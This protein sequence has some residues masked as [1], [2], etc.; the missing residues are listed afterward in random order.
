MIKIY[1]TKGRCIYTAQT[2]K[3][4]KEAV[5]QAAKRKIPLY[6]ANLCRANLRGA[7]LRGARLNHADLRMADLRD[8]DLHDADLTGADWHYA[9]M[10][11]LQYNWFAVPETF[12][13]PP[14]THAS[15]IADAK[16][17]K[18]RQQA[19]KDRERARLHRI[20]E[21]RKAEKKRL[22]AQV[23]AL[24]DQAKKRRFQARAASAA[25]RQQMAQH[26]EQHP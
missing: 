4:I 2:A 14:R 15:K 12:E 6:G 23:C 17:E 8:A 10:D 18:Q 19:R 3:T 7:H 20:A 25:L 9:T 16:R 11:G 13:F 24:K 1:N 5:E 26:K 22:A 21:A